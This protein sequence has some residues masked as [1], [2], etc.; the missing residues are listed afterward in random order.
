[1]LLS[2]RYKNW[3]QFLM[4][5]RE[6]MRTN[7][8]TEVT[9]PVLV[10]AGAIE[11]YLDPLRVGM[12][13]ELHTSPEFEM[14]RILCDTRIPIYQICPVFRDDPPSP[15]HKREFMMLEFY[16]PEATMAE[17]MDDM[18][19][20][21]C[22]VSGKDISFDEMTVAEALLRYAEADLFSPL[23]V[24][25]QQVGKNV[26]LSA[27]DSW[28]DI[29]I[30][31]MVERVEPA[32]GLDRPAM[33]RDFPATLS[34]LAKVTGEPPVAKRFEIYWKGMELCNGFDELT[35]VSELERR[36][37]ENNRIRESLGKRP[38]PFPTVLY[39]AMKRGIPP[40]SG[41]AV[42]LDRLFQCVYGGSNLV[43]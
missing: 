42:G 22:A 2:D 26:L 36:I 40:S 39:E 41:V 16:R 9:T 14:K 13:G 37:D 12:E 28:E 3:S 19:K 43:I 33:L 23:D 29:Y 21:T 38:H 25:R 24:F 31:A 1:M 30:K 17:T 8:F 32:I 7:G 27:D 6:W 5:I 18:K 34:A 11:P 15:I 35:E 10:K 20:L 4:H